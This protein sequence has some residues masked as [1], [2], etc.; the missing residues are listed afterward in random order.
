M[1]DPMLRPGTDRCRCTACGLYFNSGGAF[2]RHRIG[3]YAPIGQTETR[4]CLTAAELT[5]R[6]WSVNETG[7]WVTE[8]KAAAAQERLKADPASDSEVEA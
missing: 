5:S 1:S 6:G 3:P 8:A 4:R 2:S 7:H